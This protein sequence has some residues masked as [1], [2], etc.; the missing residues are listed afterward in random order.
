MSSQFAYFE[1]EALDWVYAMDISIIHPRSTS[2]CLPLGMTKWVPNKA[3]E[4]MQKEFSVEELS[5]IYA[6]RIDALSIQVIHEWSLK[7]V[8]TYPQNKIV[9]VELV[10]PDGWEGNQYIVWGIYR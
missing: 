1:S 3:P 5:S 6:H 10:N 9:R 7:L 2:L 8:T 4:W